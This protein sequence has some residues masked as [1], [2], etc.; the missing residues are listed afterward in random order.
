[1]GCCLT[2]SNN[3]V[4]MKS[5]KNLQ[6]HTDP[7]VSQQL[8]KLLSSFPITNSINYENMKL[9]ISQNDKIFSTEKEQSF[10]SQRTR[11]GP[12]I[13]KLNIKKGSSMSLTVVINK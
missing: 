7:G 2:T 6:S 10:Q 4:K 5:F 9:I 12:I 13:S 1:M 3:I 8:N 11:S